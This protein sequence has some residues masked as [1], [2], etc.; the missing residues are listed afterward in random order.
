MWNSYSPYP[1]LTKTLKHVQGVP[2]RDMDHDFGPTTT[3]ENDSCLAIGLQNV[4]LFAK[5]N[6]K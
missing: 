2:T 5:Q 1:Q 6:N 4:V 3:L